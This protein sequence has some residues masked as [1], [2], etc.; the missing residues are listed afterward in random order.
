MPP[1]NKSPRKTAMRVC[2]RTISRTSF[3]RGI[4]LWVSRKKEHSR[5][6]NMDSPPRTLE[7]R[8]GELGLQGENIRVH[9]DP[10]AAISH[11]PMDVSELRKTRQS[12]HFETLNLWDVL[13][14]H[15]FF[16]SLQA[17]WDSDRYLRARA[18]SERGHPRISSRHQTVGEIFPAS[19][20][21][22]S[23]SERIPGNGDEREPPVHEVC[24]KHFFLNSFKI[25]LLKFLSYLKL[26]IPEY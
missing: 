12:K 19:P 18:W 25:L 10:D 9:F 26:W 8:S 13:S 24:T 20:G 14:G 11:S 4:S 22:Q 15:G 3:S 21:G 2:W 6:S 7:R 5:D 16:N 23:V 1:G 17:L